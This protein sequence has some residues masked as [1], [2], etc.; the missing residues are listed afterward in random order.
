MKARRYFAL[1]LALAVVASAAETF[2]RAQEPPAIP[3]TRIVECLQA[4][5]CRNMKPG[6][7]NWYD[8]IGIPVMQFTED[9]VTYALSGRGGLTLWVTLKGEA[10]PS[11]HISIADDGQVSSAHLGLVVSSDGLDNYRAIRY[12][13]SMTPAESD[14]FWKERRSYRAVG[15]RDGKPQNEEFRELWQKEADAALAAIRRQIGR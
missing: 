12:P 14:A 6:Q 15:L 4:G 3:V 9:G 2:L 7:V 5:N 8:Q 1:L 10:R 11:R 13:R